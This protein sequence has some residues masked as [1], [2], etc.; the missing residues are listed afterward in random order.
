MTPRLLCLVVGPDADGNMVFVVHENT[1]NGPKIQHD[2][3]LW[4]RIHEY[5]EKEAAIL[6]TPILSKKQKQHIKKQFQVGK[7]PVPNPF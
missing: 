1:H 4:C 5:D 3:E 7:S 6:F 2:M